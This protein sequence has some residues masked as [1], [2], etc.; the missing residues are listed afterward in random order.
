MQEAQHYNAVL[1]EIRLLSNA[2]LRDQDYTFFWQEKDPDEP[3]LHGLGFAVRNS[4]LSGVEP[5]SSGRGCI[6]FHHLLTSLGPVI[7]LSIYIPILC[8]L[9]E[10]KDEFYEELESS[11]R[12]IS[13]TEHLY[14]LGD[15]N[16]SVGANHVS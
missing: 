1:Q 7:I 13:A 12:E 3:R 8:S 14:L 4:L 15:F 11:I 5:P 10:N 2:S 6:P 9:A 16:A